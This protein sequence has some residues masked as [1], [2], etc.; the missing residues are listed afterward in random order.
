MNHAHAG[1]LW[2]LF[3]VIFVFICVALWTLTRASKV[4]KQH[5]QLA[6]TMAREHGTYDPYT[7][8]H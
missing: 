4:L 8:A 6:N 1:E 3:A 2:P 7:K 5:D